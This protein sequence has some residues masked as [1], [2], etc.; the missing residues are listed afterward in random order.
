MNKKN[1]EW[2]ND[3]E[4]V[5]YSEQRHKSHSLGSCRKYMESFNDTPNYYFAILL[6]ESYEKHIG[7]ISVFV[8]VNNKIADISI[9]V[10]DRQ[11]WGKGYGGEAFIG[12]VNFLKELKIR[13]ITAGTIETNHA[14]IKIMKKARM[15]EDGRRIKHFVHQGKEVDIVYSSIFPLCEKSHT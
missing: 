14:M 7:N 6:S 2:L 1:V 9:M 5:R 3:P 13:K 12:V 15:A 10:G 11:Y 4:V 8:D